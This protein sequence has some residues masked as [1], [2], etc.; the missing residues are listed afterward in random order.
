LIEK[1]VEVEKLS[2]IFLF[3][4][5]LKEIILGKTEQGVRAVDDISFSIQK[6]EDLGVVGESGCGKTTLGKLLVRVY[7]PTSGRIFFKERDIS[8]LKGKKLKDYRK[9]TQMIFQNPYT[10]INPRFTMYDFVAEPLLIHNIGKNEK[11]R[12]EMVFEMLNKV[13]LNPPKEFSGKYAHQLSGGERQRAV[14][15]RALI[16]RPEF[17]VADEPASMLDVSLRAGILN[18]LK[19]LADELDLTVMYISHDLSL[20]R[21]LCNIIIVVYLGKFLEIGDTREVINNPLHPYTQALVAAVPVPDPNFKY[22]KVKIKGAVPTV[23]QEPSPGC[24]FVDRCP[25]VKSI[26]K[27]EPPPQVKIDGGHIVYCHLYRG[28]REIK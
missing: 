19:Q 9:K 15:A 23:P 27:E 11:E 4:R 28:G 20:I 8:K 25:Y 22:Q 6:G 26:C 2:K 3:T 1:I 14:V 16:L 18:L 21:Y 24:I 7:K 10:A 13:G 5:S 12:K 17:I